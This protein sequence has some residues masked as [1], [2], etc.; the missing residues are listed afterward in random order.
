MLISALY[1]YRPKY[2]NSAVYASSVLCL[3]A[4]LMLISGMIAGVQCLSVWKKI[5]INLSQ[6]DLFFG[7]GLSDTSFLFTPNQI[8]YVF[9]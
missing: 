1:A 6:N 5:E 7:D 3:S 2:K 4:R 9:D 8:V